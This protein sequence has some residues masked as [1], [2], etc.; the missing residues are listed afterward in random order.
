MSSGHVAF[1]RSVRR[2]LLVL[3]SSQ[4]D[5]R[6]NKRARRGSFTDSFDQVYRRRRRSI[7]GH[8]TAAE[9]RRRFW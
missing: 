4:R 7:P 3:S 9:I 5:E 6:G 8:F 1:A 2:D